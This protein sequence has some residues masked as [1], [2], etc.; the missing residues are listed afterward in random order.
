MPII[1]EQ[2]FLPQMKLALLMD[3]LLA[4]IQDQYFL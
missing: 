1:N 3:L 2:D 4:R